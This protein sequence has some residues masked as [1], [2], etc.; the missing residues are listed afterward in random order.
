[1]GSEDFAYM[2]AAC[3]G[4][5]ISIGI[6]NTDG[7]LHNPRYDFN[8]EALPVGASQ[9]ARLIEKSCRDLRLPKSAFSI[10][11]WCRAHLPLYAK[12]SEPWTKP[13][14]QIPLPARRGLCL[15]CLFLSAKYLEIASFMSPDET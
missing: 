12:V 13:T 9:F 5:L 7:P 1:M 10:A 2:L 4:A 15:K 6:G 11:K 3:P 8:D 14:S